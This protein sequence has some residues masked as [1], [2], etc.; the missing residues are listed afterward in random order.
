M[1]N[2]VAFANFPSGVGLYQF[3]TSIPNA[4]R[5]G[6]LPS[7]RF[8]HESWTSFTGLQAVNLAY[9]TAYY[10]VLFLA[11][12]IGGIPLMQILSDVDSALTFEQS[13]DAR[14]GFNL[15][16][17]DGTFKEWLW[18]NGGISRASSWAIC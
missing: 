12:R 17:L 15:E 11:G 13:L 14:A 9:G 5:D 3:D 6:T 16:T 4:L 2:V 10:A 8:L 1:A 18:A 7:L